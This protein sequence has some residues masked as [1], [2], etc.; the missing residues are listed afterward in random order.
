MALKRSFPNVHNLES[1][2]RHHL[3]QVKHLVQAKIK[4]AYNCY[5]QNILGLSDGGDEN[6]HKNSGSISKKLFSLI[7]NARQDPNTTSSLNKE[8]KNNIFNRQK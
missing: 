1:R 3:K 4:S 6:I 5:I 7:K 2:D 8:K